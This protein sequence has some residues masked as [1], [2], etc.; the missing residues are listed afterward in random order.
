VYD[1]SGSDLIDDTAHLAANNIKAY[2]DSPWVHTT[3]TNGNTVVYRWFLEDQPGYIDQLQPAR[4]VDSLL[5]VVS[6]ERVG[7]QAICRISEPGKVFDGKK[8]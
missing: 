1:Q 8:R 7:F 2:V 6:S 4:Y 3:L 5:R